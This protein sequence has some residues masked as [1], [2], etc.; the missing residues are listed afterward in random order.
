MRGGGTFWALEVVGNGVYEL[1]IIKLSWEAWKLI[2]ENL[3]FN[4]TKIRF[5]SVS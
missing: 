4:F 2:M 1:S 5:L 3:I